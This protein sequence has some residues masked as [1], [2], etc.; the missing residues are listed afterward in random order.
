RRR[1]TIFSRD[2]SSD[3]CSSDLHKPCHILCG[4][5]SLKKLLSA[6]A[7]DTLDFLAY[8]LFHQLR[9]IL[10]D[11][12]PQHRAKHIFGG[13]RKRLTANGLV[14]LVEFAEGHCDLAL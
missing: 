4:T 2:W 8:E 3:V 9:K 12:F 14:S 11:P 13:I 7:S 6:S 10:V 1:H 5:D